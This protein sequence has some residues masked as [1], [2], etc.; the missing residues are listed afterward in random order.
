M[1]QVS[2]DINGRSYAIACDDGEEQHITEL[3]HQLSGRVTELAEAVGQVGDARLLVMAG[4]LLAD[5]LNAARNGNGAGN[6]TGGD[7]GDQ[8]D[9]NLI[10]L[11]QRIESLAARAESVADHLDQT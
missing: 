2:V 4:L 10:A 9:E 8:A 3:G 5:E 11:A 7:T 6:D 1:G